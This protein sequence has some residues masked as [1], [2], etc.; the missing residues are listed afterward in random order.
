MDEADQA[1]DEFE[2][3]AASKR[4]MIELPPGATT[5]ID[6]DGTTASI[7]VW[8]YWLQIAESHAQRAIEARPSDALL[9]Y[10]S[11]QLAQM[12]VP[13]VVAAEAENGARELTASMVA[14]GAAA[15]A[16]DGFYGGFKPLVNPP[17]SDAKRS[18]QI[19]EAL[20]LGFKIGPQI[21]Q[22]LIDLDWLFDTR[23]GIVHHAEMFRPIVVSRVTDQTLVAGG[24]E[25]FELGSG[26]A[27]RA[28]EIARDVM[29]TCVSRPKPTTADWAADHQL[30]DP[31][32]PTERP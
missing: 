30:P 7:P 2:P 29:S 6:P 13:P 28:A 12:N 31:V 27:K 4:F 21:N 8:L 5:V 20:K 16:L 23:D 18:R 3:G 32:S 9:D 25:L 15:H 10:A 24:P 26:N 22:W 11:A 14:I 19:L 17:S 1:T